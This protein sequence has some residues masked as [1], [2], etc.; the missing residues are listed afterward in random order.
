MDAAWVGV[1][2]TLAGALAGGGVS[3]YTNFR[4]Q[5]HAEK[6]ARLGKQKE[7]HNQLWYE[8]LR[9]GECV[10]RKAPVEEYQTSKGEFLET[11]HH[12]FL[13]IAP[14]AR[15]SVLEVRTVVADADQSGYLDTSRFSK[16][17]Q[18]ATRELVATSG[19]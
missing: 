5:Q 16:A 12:N 1:I 10:H 4:A 19:V 11:L 7:V 2:G 8:V 15:E 3:V 6:L 14:E 17:V 13:Y 9:L 18:A